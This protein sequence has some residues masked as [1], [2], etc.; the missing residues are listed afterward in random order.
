MIAWS[1]FILSVC[2]S[3]YSQYWQKKAAILFVAQPQLTRLQ[4]ILSL[5]I[6]LSLLFLGLAAFSWLF[7]L[8][9]WD[10]SQAYPRLSINFVAILILSHFTFNEPISQK[11]CLGC[12]LIIIGIIMLSGGFK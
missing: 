4:K 3:T 1:F 11:Q 8:H 7:V 12:G 6:I 9:F 5:P 10:V 2:A